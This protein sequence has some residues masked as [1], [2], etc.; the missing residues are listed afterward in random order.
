M[1]LRIRS[2]LP[3]STGWRSGSCPVMGADI[4][5]HQADINYRA[6][7]DAMKRA[8]VT[9]LVSIS[10]C[11]SFREELAPGVFVLVD[12][13][14]DRTYRA[15]KEL[16]SEPVWSPTFQSPIRS[17]QSSSTSSRRHFKAE[18]IPLSARRHVSGHGGARSFPVVQKANSIRSWGCAV[19]GMTN[20]PEA[21]LAREAEILLRDRG[22]GYRLRLLA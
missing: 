1:S 15:R 7:I 22:H 9:D 19:I 11:G 21:K 12:Q 6:N 17:A 18:S 13:F 2:C 3:R 16:S 8:G 10:A 20:M 14:I 4:G 5:F